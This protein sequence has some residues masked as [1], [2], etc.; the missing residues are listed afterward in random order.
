MKM[1]FT[2]QLLLSIQ[3]QLKIL[4]LSVFWFESLPGSHGVEQN[5]S[6]D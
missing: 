2:K 3:A 1:V 6:G 5:N 4:S